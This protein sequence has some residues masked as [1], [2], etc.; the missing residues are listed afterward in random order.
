MIGIKAS[1]AF[2]VIV[3][4]ISHFFAPTGYVFYEHTMSEMAAQFAPNAWILTTG[5]VG[6]GI[7]YIVF[8][9]HAW[10]KKSIPTWLYGLV[11]ANGVT[12]ILLAFFPTSF[13]GYTMPANETVVIIHRYIA[14]ASNFITI[15]SLG[16][17][18]YYSKGKVRYIHSIFIALAIIF[19]AFFI[20]YNQDVR[21][22]FQRLILITTSSWTWF[23]FGTMNRSSETQ[24][25]SLVR[26]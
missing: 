14:Y 10:V 3:I 7:G 2:L 1:N 17:H 9:Y 19:S 26:S 25:Q 13:D 22:V 16:L 11:I 24:A 21:G 20:G 23:Y 12:L 15:L 4:F 6:A 8:A 5:F 18:A